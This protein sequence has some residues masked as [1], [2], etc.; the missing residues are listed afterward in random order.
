MFSH[1]MIAI[2]GDETIVITYADGN[3]V[4]NE[5]G[6]TTG[7][8]HVVGNATETGTVTHSNEEIGYVT[9]IELGTD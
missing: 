8:Y 3:D 9:T 6:T 4:T 1:E 7:L 5:A 2:D